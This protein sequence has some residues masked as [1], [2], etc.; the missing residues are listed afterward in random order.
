MALEKWLN[1]FRQDRYLRRIS[2]MSASTSWTSPAPMGSVKN[3]AS[4]ECGIDKKENL[5]LHS[6]HR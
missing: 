2:G 5:V 6:L 1:I 3:A 4:L